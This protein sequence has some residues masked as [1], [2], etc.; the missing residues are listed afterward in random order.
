LVTIL[1]GVAAHRP[2]APLEP[3]DLKTSK[4]AEHHAP[5]VTSD[6]VETMSLIEF[7]QAH[8]GQV[9]VLTN[10]EALFVLTFIPD[11]TW[12]NKHELARRL[13]WPLPRLET[14]CDELQTLNLV[15]VG[16]AGTQHTVRLSLEGA[17]VSQMF[18]GGRG[19]R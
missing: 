8:R 7:Y 10:P 9:A 15:D 17:E 1:E 11:E 13:G 16:P 3:Q 18:H 5:Y 12:L 6:F 4:A 19:A 2:S 14:I